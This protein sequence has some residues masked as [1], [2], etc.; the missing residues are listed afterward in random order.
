MKQLVKR[1]INLT[2]PVSKI[3]ERELRHVSNN[4]TLD[5]MGRILARNKFA[6]VEKTKFVTTTDL[7]KMIEPPSIK[8]PSKKSC[9]EKNCCDDSPSKAAAA[10][11]SSGGSSTMDLVAAA[12]V[13]AA[14]AAAATVTY[15]RSQ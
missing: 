10:A 6:L 8:T 2:D 5:E 14:V 4:I 1:R 12:V 13:G 11:P 3:V 15:M 7:L 9:A